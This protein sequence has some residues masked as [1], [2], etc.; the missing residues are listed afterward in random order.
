MR[1]RC[2]LSRWIGVMACFFTEMRHEVPASFQ[3]PRPAAR[4]TSEDAGADA[5]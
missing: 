2:S 4:R 5:G 1:C 3:S